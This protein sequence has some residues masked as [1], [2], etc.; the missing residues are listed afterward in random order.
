MTILTNQR[1]TT[2]TKS[3]IVRDAL[4][5]LM[6]S[7]GVGLLSSLVFVLVVLLFSNEAL[8]DLNDEQPVPNEV[9]FSDVQQGSLL[10]KTQ[11]SGVFHIAPTVDTK[12]NMTVTGMLLRSR[13]S[14]TFTNPD[15]HWVEGIY[16]FPLPENA[17]VDHM[18]MVIGERV[19]IGEIKERSTAKKLYAKAK[20]EG[21]KAALIEQERPNVF[22]N[23]VA[24]IG[25]NESITIEIEY[26]QTL[27]YQQRQGVGQFELR[28]PMT[29]TPRYI[30]GKPAEPA[31]QLES[32]NTFQ[33]NGWALNTDVVSDASRISPPHHA[34]DS[35]TNPVSLTI[36]LNAGFP[37][38]E[39]SSPYHDIHTTY[40]DEGH[41]VITLAE[42]VA[43]ADRDFSLVWSIDSGYAPKA[44][45]FNETI[46]GELY[47]LIMV[48]PPTDGISGSQH[49]PR[50][51]VYIIDTSGSMGGQSIAQAKA[52]LTFALQRLRTI[53]TFNVI[54]FNSD[55]SSV[56]ESALPATA[57]NLRTALKYVDSLYATGGTEMLPALSRAL[58]GNHEGAMVRQLI[59]LT[60][61]SVG[62]EDQLFSLIEQELGNSRLFTIGIGAAPNSFFMTKAAQFGRGTF[63]YIGNAAEVTTKMND[64]F[65]KLE[66]PVM[67]NLTLRWPQH[68]QAEV[69]PKR[70]P[71]LYLG[72]PLILSAKTQPAAGDV[73][74]EG[75]RL[76]TRWQLNMPLTKSDASKEASGVGS[77]WA[78]RKI[79]SLM[80]AIHE[81]A[82]KNDIKAAVVNVAL[83]HHLVSKFTSLV[84]VDKAPLRPNGAPVNSQA[85]ANKIPHGSTMTSHGNVVGSF[86]N[87][88]SAAPV[89]IIIGLLLLTFSLAAGWRLNRQEA[90]Y[91]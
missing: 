40:E 46:D 5:G 84:A 53:D 85:V 36:D 82:D 89:K 58:M 10:F 14:Q 18:R 15:N 38:N 59:F 29:L 79:D 12:V 76:N 48:M 31:E 27:T 19:V 42:G 54:Q 63:T 52:A 21:K 73:V 61:G 66:T 75:E 41:S 25:P 72:E 80:D 74:I 26:Q 55:V 16:V 9:G 35:A 64:L 78:R 39:I 90:R 50:E 20:R 7:V 83:Q 49:M 70:L 86:A 28:F 81:G 11:A 88:A 37:I 24:N 17:A 57:G 3:S 13:V 56:F 23:S 91:A 8:A 47:H 67:T 77:L 1:L 32:V 33:G 22:T 4:L 71:D 65:T 30:P 43:P 68:L 2:V 60:D 87:T 6:A 44:A 62:N 69:W 45:L 34:N 51:V